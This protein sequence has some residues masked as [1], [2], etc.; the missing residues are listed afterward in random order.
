[1]KSSLTVA[2]PVVAMRLQIARIH[3][4]DA[5]SILKHA[6]LEEGAL[7]DPLDRLTLARDKAIWQEI[8]AATGV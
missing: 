6:G 2:T 7:H 1:M 4:I 5:V 3:G 8:I